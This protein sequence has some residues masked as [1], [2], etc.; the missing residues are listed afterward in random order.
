[1]THA[2]AAALADDDLDRAIES[3]LLGS[4]GC[5]DCSAACTSALIVQ[6]DARLDALAARERYRQRNARLQRRAAERAARRAPPPA[7]DTPAEAAAPIRPALPSAAAAALAR[8]K[9]KAAERHKP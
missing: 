5:T 6:R 2:I 3:G 8:A 1:M 4:N 7:I 9:A